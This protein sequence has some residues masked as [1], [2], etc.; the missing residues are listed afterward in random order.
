VC[1]CVYHNF[2]I[3]LLV[4][5]HLACFQTLAIVTSATVNISVQVSLLYPVLCS[6]Q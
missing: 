2:L 5:G 6:F 4:V 3:H 1:V